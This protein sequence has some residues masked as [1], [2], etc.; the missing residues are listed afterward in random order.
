MFALLKIH[1]QWGARWR[2]GRGDERRDGQLL[3]SST[4]VSYF[5]IA[6]TEETAG[7]KPV[8]SIP[9]QPSGHGMSKIPTTLLVFALCVSG[10]HA[11]D[12]ELTS[13]N[14]T[15]LHP[16]CIAKL[17]NDPPSSSPPKIQPS[18]P[19]PSPPSPRTSTQTQA[20]SGWAPP[21][22]LPTRPRRLSGA[23]EAIY[24]AAKPCSLL[25]LPCFSLVVR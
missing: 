5:L 21:T 20:T 13:R 23:K 8:Y 11:I 2:R 24:R 6:A 3:C 9:E 18:S 17:Y 12:I 7:K 22:L 1:R 14:I 19:P 16:P 25:L 10:F 4:S 15:H